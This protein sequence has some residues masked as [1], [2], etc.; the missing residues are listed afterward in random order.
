ME[1]K[2]ANVEKKLTRL[3]GEKEKRVDHNHIIYPRQVNETNTEK[4]LNLLNKA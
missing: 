1:K 2:Y 4:E 3:R